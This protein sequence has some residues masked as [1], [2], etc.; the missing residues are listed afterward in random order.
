MATQW[1]R[2]ETVIWPPHSPIY[3]YGAVFLAL[4]CTGAF[5]WARF[6][7]GQSPL[8][9]FYTPAYAR[10]TASRLSKDR[11]DKFR[12]LYVGNGVIAGRLATEA[13]VAEGSTHTQ[14][15]R[16]LPLVLSPAAAAQGFRVLYQGRELSYLDGPL[17]A[18]LRGTIF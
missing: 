3:T 8:Q 18:Y 14:D 5:L 11:R 16:S 15:G 12:L 6:T 17:H 2:K 1:G 7:F 4:V 13:D 9:Q 10:T